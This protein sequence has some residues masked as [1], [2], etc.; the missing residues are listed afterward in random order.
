MS[1]LIKNTPQDLLIKYKA[2]TY[3]F[4]E[5]KLNSES[6]DVPMLMFMLALLG[7]TNE[8][9]KPL[10]SETT[11][12]GTHQFSIRTLYQRNESDLDAYI[13]LI[14]IL[15]NMNLPM[16]EVVNSIAFE[17]T[18]VN[19]TP[20]LKMKNVRTFFEYMLGGIDAFVNTFFIYGKGNVEMVDAIH[21]FLISDYNKIDELMRNMLMEETLQDE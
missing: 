8:I 2:S 19:N 7:F 12:E 9:S 4:I 21:D 14:T 10:E 13:G 16:D 6:R 1:N 11:N 18:S 15:D 17:R 20:F 5:K 3:E